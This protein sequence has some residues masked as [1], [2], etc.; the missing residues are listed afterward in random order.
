M[1]LSGVNVELDGNTAEGV[2]AFGIDG[3]PT[4]QGTLAAETIDISSYVSTVR[5]LTHDRARVERPADRA[6][7]PHRLRSRPA[8]VGRARSLLPGAKLGRTAIAATLRGGRLTLTIGES[9]AFG[10]MLKGSVGVAR[11]EAGVELKAQLQFTDVDLER[12]LGELFAVRRLEGKGSLDLTV[13]GAGA[14]VLALTRTLNGQAKLLARQGGAR[15]ASVSSRCCG[16]WSGGRCPGAGISAAGA[17]RSNGS[18]SRSRSRTA[19]RPSRTAAWKA[20]RSGWRSAAR[21]RSRAAISTSRAPPAS[22]RANTSDPARVRAAVRGAGALG[23]PGHAAGRPTADPALGSGGAAARRG[24]RAARARCGPLGDRTLTR[25]PAPAL[26]ASRTAAAPTE[27][28]QPPPPLAEAGRMTLPNT[29]CGIR[30]AKRGSIR[31]GIG[32]ACRPS[33]FAIR[34]LGPA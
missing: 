15:R 2:L 8:S 16:G 5:A 1:T 28:R 3:R 19:P 26:S 25:V 31:H 34:R 27:P 13:E 18:P 7:Q 24:A 17:R 4:L 32:D 23:G 21:R 30:A 11:A 10:G 33:P 9:Q 29:E 12:C 20:R 14:S 22:S 6:Q